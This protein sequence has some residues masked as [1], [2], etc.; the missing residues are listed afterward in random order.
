MTT[1]TANRLFET[2]AKEILESN[3][4]FYPNFASYLG[5]HEYDG[6][7]PDISK[8]ALGNRARELEKQ[9][10]QLENIDVTALS[11][12]NYF[13]H[14]IML[15]A[16]RKELFDLTNLKLYENNPV[17]LVWHIDMSNYIRR[18]YAPF[19][20]R[21]EALV[22]AL[23][24][25]PGVVENMKRNLNPKL[26]ESIIEASIE[27][28]QGMVAFYDKDIVE[29]VSEIKGQ[30]IAQKFDA[31]RQAASSSVTAFVDHM[32]SI[33]AGASSNFAIGAD[34]FSRLLK[35]GEMVEMSLERLLEAGQADLANNLAKFQRLSQEFDSSKTPAKVME[36][37]A[38]D[39]PEADNLIPETRGMLEDI[40]QYLIDNNIV[41]VPSEIRC[42]TIETPTFMR[43]AFAALDFPGPLEEKANE[44]FYYVTP[45]EDEWSDEEKEQ[46][47]TSFNYPT[48]RSVSIHEAYPGHYVHY[49]HTRNSQ[50]K[51]SLIYGA[52]SFWEGW[53][54]YTEQ[55]MIEEGYGSDD[56]RN[57]LGQLMEALLR[58]CRYICA[59]RM[60]TQGMTVKEA[61]TFFMENAFMEELPA[62]REAMRGTFDPMYLN[63]TL[64]KLMIL[65][66]REDYKKEQ[67]NAYSIKKFHDTFLS[68]GAPPI[69][70]VREMM[71][72]NPGQDVL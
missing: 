72:R 29:A 42:Q 37:I 67:G 62:K 44:T 18:D 64:G 58:D 31:A 24:A 4:E 10:E 28:Y 26:G 17:E 53:A 11:R 20:Q 39:H 45:V 12:Q 22:N 60:H 63:Y 48:L 30:E 49:L 47:L 3:H 19:Q 59:I 57:A 46:W 14:A 6:R 1:N 35:N 51:I 8:A 55:M 5:L 34:R 54:H 41:T 71:L 21:V 38:K 9:A 27:A 52:Y 23:Q 16:L 69:P 40:R 33:Q 7:L 68:F 66:L 25:V 56:P 61:T 65:K 13:D 43:W 70:L 15:S 50:S 32:K 2:A 36:S